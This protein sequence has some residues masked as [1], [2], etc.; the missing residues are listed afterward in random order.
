MSVPGARFGLV[1]S[2]QRP[3][4]MPVDPGR[5]R[6][7][8]ELADD[9]GFDS[10]WA[11]DHL[12]FA[13]PILEGLVALSLFA[14]CTRR[15]ALGAGVYLLPLRH[16]VA[17]AKQV[18]TLDWLSGGRVVFGVGLGGDSVA[19]FDAVGVPLAGR[20][21][22]AEEGIACL[23]ALWAGGPATHRGA[24]YAFEDVELRPPP[25]RPG[26]PPIVLG[27]GT[28][29]TLRRV[30]ELADGWLAHMP[31]PDAFARDWTAVRAHAAAAGRDPDALEPLALLPTHVDLDEGRALA[32][33]SGRLER[34]YGRGL[35]PADVAARCLVG[36]P[37]TVRAQIEA[38]LAAGVRHVVL[39]PLVRDEGE[40]DAIELLARE[41]VAPLRV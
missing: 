21:R 19:E 26:G 11:T 15:I 29:R 41:V 20:G 31:G 37:A 7:V 14:G 4:G 17:V 1:G 35:A 39:N 28:A 16:P 25:A 33:A 22:R 38:Y 30:G 18:A 13:S 2:G 34:R 24:H 36:T 40:L 9:L 6:A 23:R 27:G 8:A 10:L 5:Y 32:V 3:E 12:A